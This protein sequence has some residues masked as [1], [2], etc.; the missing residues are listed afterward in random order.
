MR[1]KIEKTGN[2]CIYMFRESLL[3]SQHHIQP[4]NH[5]QTHYL[6]STKFSNVTQLDLQVPHTYFAIFD[7]SDYKTS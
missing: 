1:S 3:F 7:C 2:E 5:P 6:K 4:I